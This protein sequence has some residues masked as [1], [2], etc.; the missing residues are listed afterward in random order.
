M[1][2]GVVLIALALLLTAVGTTTAWADDWVLYDWSVNINGTTYNPPGLPGSVNSAGF[3]FGTGLGSM[4]I[5]FNNPGA[6]YG[7]IYLSPYWGSTACGGDCIDAYGTVNGLLPLNLSY[8]IGWPGAD[9]GLGFTVFDLFAAN[10]LDNTNHVPAYSPPGP[11]SSPCC[12][13]ALAENFGFTLG[14]GENGILTFNT[15]TTAPQS[16]FYLQVTDHDTGQNYYLTESF[17]IETQG[18]PEPTSA[19][20]LIAGMGAVLGLRRKAAASK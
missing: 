7:G 14:A 13:V 19:L 10:T 4:T 5:T 12:D 6:N 8:S 15:S 11:L 9:L 20:L 16:G 18:A 2:N 1:K 3:D 17:N